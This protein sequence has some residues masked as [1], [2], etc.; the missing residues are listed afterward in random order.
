MPKQCGLILFQSLKAKP[1][2]SSAAKRTSG[3]PSGPPIATENSAMGQM[4]V[5]TKAKQ[6]LQ[7]L[8]LSCRKR[9]MGW[10]AASGTC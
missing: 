2:N 9:K 1:L 8:R 7:G 3:N 10:L 5:A 4:L 6:M